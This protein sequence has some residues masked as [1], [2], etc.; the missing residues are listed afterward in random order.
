MPEAPSSPRPA[1][2]DRL[3]AH[4][5]GCPTISFDFC[6][7]KASGS[8]AIGDEEEGD[9]AQAGLEIERGVCSQT[10]YLLALPLKSKNQMSLITSSWPSPNEPTWRWTLKILVTAGCQDYDENHQDL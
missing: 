7:V 9:G 2:A 6:Y 10:G 3:E 5:Q 1:L 8:G 4:E